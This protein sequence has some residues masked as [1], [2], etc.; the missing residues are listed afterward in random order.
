MGLSHLTDDELIAHALSLDQMSDLEAEL[1][2]RFELSIG[3][4]DEINGLSSYDGRDT[5]TA[6]L[7]EVDL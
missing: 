2:T 4:L 1:L 6:P 3:L 7:P 5:L